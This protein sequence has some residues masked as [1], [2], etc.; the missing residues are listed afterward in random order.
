LSG[1]DELSDWN[2]ELHISS[3][4][5]IHNKGYWEVIHLVEQCQSLELSHYG[6]V[7][8]SSLDD[9]VVLR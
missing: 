4:I 6:Q 3:F 1:F 7:F 8:S 2:V 9:R 5:L